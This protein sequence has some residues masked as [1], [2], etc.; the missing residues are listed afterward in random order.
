MLFK[1]NYRHPLNIGSDKHV[2]INKL[3]SVLENI[4]GNKFKRKYDI[5][6]PQGVKSR[7]SDNTLIKKILKWS[8][9]I[10]MKEGMEKIYYHIKSFY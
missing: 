9:E 5:S 4:S 10:T 8:P 6:K 1:S 7:S 3:V 2:T